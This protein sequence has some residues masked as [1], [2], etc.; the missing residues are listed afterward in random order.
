MKATVKINREI[1]M[2]GKK[3]VHYWLIECAKE[4]KYICRD[5]NAKGLEFCPNGMP[6]RTLTAAKDFCNRNG[7]DYI[8]NK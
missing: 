1:R 7:F 4:V 5:F 6:F 8:Y 2:N 3:Y